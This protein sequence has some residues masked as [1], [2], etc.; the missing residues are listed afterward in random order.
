MG[1]YSSRDLEEYSNSLRLYEE[2]MCLGIR[3]YLVLLFL[4]ALL[5]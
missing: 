1:L 4:A 5:L 3:D 2:N